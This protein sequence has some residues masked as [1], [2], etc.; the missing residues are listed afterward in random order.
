MHSHVYVCVCPASFMYE[1]F[2]KETII[3]WEIRCIFSSRF[4]YRECQPATI[5]YFS[6]LLTRKNKKNKN[7]KVLLY[8][9]FL[10]FINL[11]DFHFSLKIRRIFVRIASMT[12]CNLRRHTIITHVLYEIIRIKCRYIK[13]GIV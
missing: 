12:S 3:V 5:E 6:V 10:R 11:L 9:K 7:K 8:L 1:T 2:H 13:K 4:H